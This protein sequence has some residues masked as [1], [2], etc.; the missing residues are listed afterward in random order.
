M[1]I[2][3]DIALLRSRLR[4]VKYLGSSVALA[5]WDQEVHMPPKASAARAEL[6][7]YL[8][9]EQH[10]KFVALDHDKLLTRLRGAKK[11]SPKNTALVRELW[12][13]YMLATKLPMAFVVEFASTTSEAQQV[14]AEARRKNDFELFQPW[15][16]KI[17][18]LSKEKA[19]LLGGLDA[20][21]TLLDTFEPE[22]TSRELDVTF[23]A[24]REQLVALLARIQSANQPKVRPPK[25]MFPIDQQRTLL[26]AMLPQM[27]FDMEAGRIDESTHPF[28]TDIHPFD[29]RITTRYDEKNIWSSVGSAIHEL[30]HALYEQGLPAGES[31]TPLGEAASLAIHESQSRF[32]ENMVGKNRQTWTHFFPQMKKAFPKALAGYSADEW[33]RYLNTVQPSLIRTESDEVTY[34]LH[35]ILRFEIER[36]LIKNNLHVKDLPH[37]W[38]EK[39]REYIGI[40]VPDNARGVLQ[41]VHWSGGMIGYFPTYTLGN[42]YSAQ[43]YD[44]IQ[45]D[46][47]DFGVK[48]A[49]GDYIPIRDWLRDTIHRHGRYYSAKTLMRRTAGSPLSIDPF[50]RYLTE[51]YSKLYGF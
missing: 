5:S 2:K 51:K 46:L 3:K 24:L 32:W 6:L 20:Y 8:S 31:G 13:D 35:I 16:E 42:L 18:K 17:V 19:R 45:R 10:T 36:D 23:T 40:R 4:E 29:A 22:M 48:L 28:S 37:V 30:G 38:N 25:G 47:P 26:D 9:G 33:Y 14:W 44:A 43:L 11:L 39:M 12:R 27:G 21:D 49:H 15:L 34:N 7:A 50:M 41:D 1:D